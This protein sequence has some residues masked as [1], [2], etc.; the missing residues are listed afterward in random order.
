[1]RSKYFL[2]IQTNFSYGRLNPA[3]ALQEDY[4]FLELIF[5][6]IEI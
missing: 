1:M 2:I 3:R 4:T 6:I 5:G